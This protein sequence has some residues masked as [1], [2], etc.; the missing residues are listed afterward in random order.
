MR[1]AGQRERR[2]LAGVVE[3]QRVQ[4]RVYGAKRRKNP[5]Y[6][7]KTAAYQKAYAQT[8]R[9]K[10]SQARRNEEYLEKRK[11]EAMV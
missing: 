3:R 7:A 5:E 10:A 2:K 9:A 6:K 11:A 1:A 4:N 8:P